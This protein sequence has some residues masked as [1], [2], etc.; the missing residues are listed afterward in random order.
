VTIPA[1]F[2]DSDDLES[3]V[4][5]VQ[6]Q[7]QRS[8]ED[9]ETVRL[10]K[11]IVAG[12]ADT[13]IEGVPVIYAWQL[14][15][16]LSTAEIVRPAKSEADQIVA[17]WNFLVLNVRYKLDPQAFE[18]VSTL[19]VML[20]AGEEDCDGSTVAFGAL[21]RA[22]GFKVRARVISTNGSHWEH[23]YAQVGLPK[24]RPTRWLTLD[25]TVRGATPGWEYTDSVTHRADFAL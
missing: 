5:I 2:F 14:P 19:R 12:R 24:Q 13:M 9:P 1:A 18:L 17:I 6:R 11:K 8:L 16:Q 21:L 10:A 23:I 3:H 22:L 15:H 20:E 4:S 7:V 25:P